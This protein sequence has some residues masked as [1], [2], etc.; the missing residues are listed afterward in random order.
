VHYSQWEQCHKVK[1]WHF[2]CRIYPSRVHVTT[3]VDIQML[4]NTWYRTDL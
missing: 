4:E 3:D 2:R 1:F